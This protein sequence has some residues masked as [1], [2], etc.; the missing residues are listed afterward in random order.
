[1]DTDQFPLRESPKTLTRM[2]LL[3]PLGRLLLPQLLLHMLLLPQ[4]SILLLPQLSILLLPHL[5]HMLLPQLL[6]RLL[7]SRLLLPQLLSRLLLPQLL[8]TLLPLPQ[9]S[10]MLATKSTTKFSTFPRSL[11]KST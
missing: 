10:N 6:S 1:M 4:L 9:L 8:P 11:S 5:L 3:I 7:K 2:D